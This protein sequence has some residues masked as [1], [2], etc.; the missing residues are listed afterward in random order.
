MK[1][2]AAA[3]KLCHSGYLK[4]T[5]PPGQNSNYCQIKP[6]KPEKTQGL[7][8]KTAKLCHNPPTTP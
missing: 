2:I 1:E 3:I 4:A 6:H 7:F 5:L 8:A